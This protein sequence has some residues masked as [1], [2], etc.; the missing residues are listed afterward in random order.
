M[1]STKV[2]SKHLSMHTQFKLIVKNELVAVNGKTLVVSGLVV[3]TLKVA[4]QSSNFSKRNTVL[5]VVSVG[6]LLIGIAIGVDA[7]PHV[8]KLTGLV[9]Q[10]LEQLWPKN[11]LSQVSKQLSFWH[12]LC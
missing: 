11:P 8:Y 5:V 7:D 1:L 2:S 3:S 12:T 9:L 10:K 6:L 4:Q